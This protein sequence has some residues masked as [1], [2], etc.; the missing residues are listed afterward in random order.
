MNEGEGR[1]ASLRE[2]LYGFH[3]SAL[4][5]PD[6]A[7]LERLDHEAG[8]LLADGAASLPLRLE[9]G[10]LA[11]TLTRGVDVEAARASYA[12]L[13]A[14]N[15]E[16]VLCPPFGFEYLGTKAGGPGED[17]AELTR[18]YTDH[19]I[20]AVRG[21]EGRPDQASVEL[22]VLAVL[23]GA[24]ARALEETNA[25]AAEAIRDSQLTFLKSHVTRWFPGFRDAV[26]AHD[27]FGFHALVV[28]SAQ[29]F[30]AHDVA[31]LRALG[32]SAVKEVD[33]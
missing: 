23:A 4:L 1:L 17:L 3:A 29:A 8:R 12:R 7:R 13:F 28:D 5:L 15:A 14:S 25:D 31:V 27:R 33:A 18:F 10:R 22:E 21:L 16:G 30:L 32:G 26:R 11:K 2:G 19:G 20:E 9:L 6:P 24:E